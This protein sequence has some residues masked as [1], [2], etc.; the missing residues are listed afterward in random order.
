MRKFTNLAIR[1]LMVTATVS[2]LVNGAIAASNVDVRNDAGTLIV[3]GDAQPNRLTIRQVGSHTFTVASSDKE[4]MIN[5]G[6][7]DTFTRVK[8]I[9]V[10]LHEG[11][12]YLYITSDIPQYS[13]SSLH[14]WLYV[15]M[16]AGDDLLNISRF[17]VGSYAAIFTGD[18]SQRSTS[19]FRPR[20]SDN[21]IVYFYGLLVDGF[22]YLTTGRGNDTIVTRSGDDFAV[23]TALAGAYI[24]TGSQSI[25]R[26]SVYMEGLFTWSGIDIETSRG[27]DTVYLESILTYNDD[28]RIDTHDGDDDVQLTW[29]EDG[30]NM[31]WQLTAFDTSLRVELGD[32]END[33]V[34]TGLTIKGNVELNGGDQQDTVSM[35]RVTARQQL[36]V[37]M[38]HG[39][40]FLKLRNC[41]A[42]MAGLNGG[43]HHVGDTL[44]LF[45]CEFEVEIAINWEQ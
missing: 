13:L 26:D 45:G 35:D 19:P 43:L 31:D 18:Y 22:L 25:S 14:Q 2:T 24:N 34:I 32:G 10:T 29:L 15:D 39:D 27:P 6:R 7:S 9:K 41:E 37:D 21:D 23:N 16:G 1:V 8:A 5:G 33:C 40:D 36:L 20:G 17:R 28:L 42:E 30:W 44:Q 11:N 4:T 38:R 12:D 3:T